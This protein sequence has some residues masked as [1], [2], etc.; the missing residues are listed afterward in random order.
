[1]A[2]KIAKKSKADYGRLR[3]AR[4]VSKNNYNYPKKVLNSQDPELLSTEFH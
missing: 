3:G 2:E 1:M 4:K